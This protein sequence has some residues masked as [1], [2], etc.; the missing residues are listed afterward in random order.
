MVETRVLSKS[1]N[2]WADVFASAQMR[3]FL[4]PHNLK[5]ELLDKLL[6]KADDV[7][8]HWH[9]PVAKLM[10]IAYVHLQALAILVASA[11]AFVIL[12]YHN[13]GL[14]LSGKNTCYT[15]KFRVA[16]PALETV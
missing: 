4:T 15:T 6:H 5:N 12:I 13:P 11:Q 9:L 2:T 8:I 14:G 16:N 10:S 1:S 7:K 3:A